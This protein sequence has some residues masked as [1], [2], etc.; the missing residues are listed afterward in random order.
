MV[1]YPALRFA[2]PDT[3]ILFQSLVSRY[4]YFLREPLRQ[5]THFSMLSQPSW[6]VVHAAV[7]LDEAHDPLFVDIVKRVDP[8]PCCECNACVHLSIGGQDYFV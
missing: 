3:I 4:Q 5:D 7:G 6:M 8:P 2:K 1:V